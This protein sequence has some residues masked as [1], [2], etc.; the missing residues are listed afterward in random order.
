MRPVLLT[1]QFDLEAK[2]SIENMRDQTTFSAVM[3]GIL[4]LTFCLK[5][6]DD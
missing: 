1:G 5:S 2:S 4:G 6:L 3:V